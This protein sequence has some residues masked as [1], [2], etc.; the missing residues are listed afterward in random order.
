MFHGII[1]NQE[2]SYYLSMTTFGSL[3]FKEWEITDEKKHHRLKFQQELF[4]TDGRGN[5][6]D[7]KKIHSDFLKILLLHYYQSSFF[8]GG[9]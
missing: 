3:F 7:Q 4:A 6:I 8:K 9:C 1:I 2:F 5:V